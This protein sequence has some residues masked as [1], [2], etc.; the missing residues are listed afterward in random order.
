MLVYAAGTVLLKDTLFTSTTGLRF[1]QQVLH[2]PGKQGQITEVRYFWDN[3]PESMQFHFWAKK[4]QQEALMKEA[5][6]IMNTFS[7]R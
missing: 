1:R 3:E 6:N 4:E 5:E 2:M 7:T